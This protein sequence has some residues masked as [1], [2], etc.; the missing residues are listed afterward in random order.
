[1]T[2][3]SGH[4]TWVCDLTRSE[5]LNMPCWHKRASYSNGV[6]SRHWA[7]CYAFFNGY[8]V[9]GDY[10]SGNLYSYDLDQPLDNGTQRKWLRMWRG[11]PQP[12]PP[13]RRVSPPDI[14]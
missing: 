1:M 13:P 7:T 6:F 3:A 14:P 12:A 2:S 5:Q 9:V 10:Q 11:R 4:G 8:C